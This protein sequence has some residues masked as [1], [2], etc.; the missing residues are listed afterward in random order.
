MVM[1]QDA[2]SASKAM[3]AG[4]TALRARSAESKRSICQNSGS[5]RPPGSNLFSMML[6]P[7]SPRRSGEFSTQVDASCADTIFALT[8]ERSEERRVGKEYKLRGEQ[9]D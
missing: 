3:L 5:F 2:P 8:S 4:L 6:Q 1:S 9:D 7:S